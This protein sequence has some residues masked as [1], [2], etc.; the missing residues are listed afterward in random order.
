MLGVSE[1]NSADQKKFQDKYKL[2]FTLVADN[3][4][5]VAEAFGVPFRGKVTARQS[6]L[7]RDGKVVWNM[8]EKTTTATHA[9]DVLAAYDALPKS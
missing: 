4:G 2:P 6:F 3:D 9:Q 7:V 1:D 5:K 8:L